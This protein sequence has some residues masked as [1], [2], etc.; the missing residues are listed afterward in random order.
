M[1]GNFHR[2]VKVAVGDV[3]YLEWDRKNFLVAHR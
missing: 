2:V 1:T 3:F